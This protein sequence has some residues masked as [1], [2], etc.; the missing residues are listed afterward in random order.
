MPFRAH[1][2]I[3]RQRVSFR[4]SDR[5]TFTVVVDV[6]V[7]F[8]GERVPHPPP[9]TVARCAR[10]PRI[11][12]PQT[13]ALSEIGFVGYL[14][15]VV[16]VTQHERRHC[17]IIV[18]AEVRDTASPSSVDNLLLDQFDFQL[19]GQVFRQ[20]CKLSLKPFPVVPCVRPVQ[21]QF[22]VQFSPSCVP[23]YDHVVL[24]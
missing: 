16:S 7:Q 9:A 20:P 2:R 8:P 22:S 1:S 10:Q 23:V 15:F 5:F 3:A 4:P 6:A 17:A 12:L 18:L 13:H 21:E 24:S 19:F 14:L 11:L